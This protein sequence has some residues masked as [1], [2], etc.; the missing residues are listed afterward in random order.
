[1]SWSKPDFAFFNGTNLFM[2]PEGAGASF[3]STF[4]VLTEPAWRVATGM[5]PAAATRTY[6][7][8]SYHELV[9]MP[10]FVGRFDI[11]SVRIVDRW[12]RFA[13]YPTGSVTPARRSQILEH[14][15]KYVPRQVEIFG[16][17]DLPH[18]A[19]AKFLDDRVVG[20][21]LADQ[22]TLPT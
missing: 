6:T 22:E 17:V 20:D 19:F 14:A 4:T 11:D 8:S 2:Y 15:S 13:S 1:M 9:D 5:T 21:L 18:P 7:A 12:F 10:F 16:E 3:A